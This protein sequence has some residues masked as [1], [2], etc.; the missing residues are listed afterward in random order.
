MDAG[1][2]DLGGTW[3]AKEATDELRRRLPDPALDDGAWT[4]VTVPGHW[5]SE[6]AFAMFDGPLLYRRH[7]EVAGPGTGRRSWLHFSGMFYQGDVW[8]DGAYL[9]DTEGYFFPHSFEVTENLAAGRG[10]VLAVE[11]ACTRPAD[12]RAKRNLTGIFEHWDCIDP[13]WTPGGIWAPVTLDET[14]PV[15][16]V[17]LRVTCREANAERATLDLEAEID[18]VASSTV[19]VATVVA[20]EVDRTV[21]VASGPEPVVAELSTEETLAAGVNRVTWRV[22][23]ER[24]AL[25]WPHALGGQPLHTVTVSVSTPAGCSDRRTVTTGLRQIR[26]RNFVASVNGERL[27]LKGVNCGP[28]RRALAEATP[29]QL[30]GDVDLARQAGLDLIRVHGH[31]TRPEFYDAADRAGM[32]IWQD[33]PLQWGYAR[34]RRQAARQARQAVTLLAHHPSL[35]VWCGH[36]EPLAVDVAPGSGPD[37]RAAAR[38]L[39]AQMLPTW[40]KTALD[41]SIRRA[42]EKADGS[43]PVVAHSGVLPHPAGGTDSHLYFGW[44]HGAERDLPR[45]LARLPILARFVGE[46]GAQAVPANAAF[47]HPERWPD[48]DWDELGAHHSLQKTV[49]DRHVPSADHATFDEWRAATQ[50]YQAT[51]IRFHIETLRRLKYRPT[52][53]FC[54]FLLADAQPAIT[55]S[56]LDHERQPKAGY[57]ALAAACAPVIVVADRPAAAYRPGETVALAVH[58]VN[59]LRVSIVGTTTATLRWPGGSRTWRWSGEVAADGVARVGRVMSILPSLLDSKTAEITLD[60]DLRWSPMD[61]HPATEDQVTEAFGASGLQDADTA[62]DRQGPRATAHYTATLRSGP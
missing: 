50:A 11:V 53:G 46:F 56:V 8:L 15:R 38:F 58:V 34:I 35:A 29:E 9:G 54:Q 18:T 30:G 42:L 51:V 52:G 60:L 31:V 19:S 39:A 33:L 43:R 4:D 2:M 27:F 26:M 21:A 23:V 13:A 48:L 32:L 61:G 49:L 62:R 45:A 10:H 20:A 57:H 28:T 22:L 5:R 37:H 44:Y 24:P 41:R 1:G 12:R 16:I 40:N 55:W 14:G 17:S 7:F 25:W 6:A 36:N 47:A 59:D 3:V